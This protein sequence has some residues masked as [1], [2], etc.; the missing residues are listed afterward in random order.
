VC[1]PICF[2]QGQLPL[3]KTQQ[4]NGP[5]RGS[6]APDGTSVV[7]VTAAEIKIVRIQSGRTICKIVVPGRAASKPGFDSAVFS[8]DGKTLAAGYD[9]WGE[10]GKDFIHTIAF[11]DADKCSMKRT[12]RSAPSNNAGNYLSFSSDDRLFAASADVSYVWDLNDRV[13]YHRET[14]TDGYLVKEALISSDGRWLASYA[15]KF[16]PPNT[17]GRFFITDLS[18]KETRVLISDWIL[19]FAFSGDLKKLYVNVMGS[20]ESRPNIK[21]YE[22]GTWKF[23]DEFLS[24]AAGRSFAVSPDGKLLAGGYESPFT[25]ASAENGAVLAKASHYTRT[26]ADD[27]ADRMHMITFLDQVEFSPDGKMLLTGGEDGSVKLWKL[28]FDKK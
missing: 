26:E 4:Y 14:P 15:Q 19:Q 5:H 23:V 9:S 3:T 8:H 13:E 16:V 24:D 27:L 22:V 20:R 28:D 12:I 2:A 7:L 10:N 1:L 6:F 11:Y 25:I 21:V 17:L 18:T